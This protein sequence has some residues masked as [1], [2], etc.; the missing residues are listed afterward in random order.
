MSVNSLLAPGP[1]PWCNPVF[2]N[3]VVIGNADVQG[4]LEVSGS[5]EIT[6]N[7]DVAGTLS[8]A[9]IRTN[10]ITPTLDTLQPLI[11]QSTTG[12][13]D[14]VR[15]ECAN[16]IKSDKV[17]SYTTNSDL[18][19]SG[20]GT[21]KVSV[22]S[23]LQVNNIKSVV[24]D[25]LYI[26][27]NGGINDHVSIVCTDGLKVNKI[28]SYNTNSDLVLEANGSGK[29]S[30]DDDILP[31]SSGKN[32]GSFGNPFDFVI[33]SQVQGLT[34]VIGKMTTNEIGPIATPNPLVMTG[35]SLGGINFGNSQLRYLKPPTLQSYLSQTVNS[36]ILAQVLT[37]N[38][39]TIISN[40]T[41]E[42]GTLA[43]FDP[44]TGIFT[45]PPGEDAYYQFTLNCSVID[46]VP[47]PNPL[48][49]NYYFE[50]PLSGDQ[51]NSGAVPLSA[52]G[53]GFRYI[54]VQFEKPLVTGGYTEVRLSMRCSISVSLNISYTITKKL[55]IS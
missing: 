17:S 26:L 19:L 48:F 38:T 32:I 45:M 36:T 29:I 12:P 40:Y 42:S 6:G 5:I 34:Q 3:V 14:Y 2:N 20:N 7:F 22:T 39:K 9:D 50:D 15:V 10:V 41:V 43:G 25:P 54:S 21:G 11:I 16:G 55:K 23:N 24:N 53:S 35:Y 4:N 47:V 28:S 44:V 37:A 27:P 31:K 51:I 13:K 8:A 49:M 1:K 33:A 52:D 18:Q 46:G 30:V